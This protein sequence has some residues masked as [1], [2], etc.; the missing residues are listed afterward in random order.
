MTPGAESGNISPRPP[1][2]IRALSEC[3]EA[4]GP[5]RESQVKGG[6]WCREQAAAG[7]WSMCLSAQASRNTLS[8]VHQV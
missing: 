2:L 8:M 7:E 4:G 3:L 6:A 1:G 5:L